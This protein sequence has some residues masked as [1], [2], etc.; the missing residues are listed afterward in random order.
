MNKILGLN[1]ALLLFVFSCKSKNQTTETDVVEQPEAANTIVYAKNRFDKLPIKIGKISSQFISEQIS[2]TGLVDVPPE[3]MASVSFVIGGSIKS[4]THNILPGKYVKKGSVLAV[5]QSI[6][7]L[8]IQDDYLQSFTKSELLIQEYTR[9]KS[10]AEEDAGAKRKLQEAENNL[11]LNKAMLV[12]LEA[13]L[14]LIGVN[15]EVLKKGKILPVFNIYSPING[16]IKTANVSTGKNFT[17]SDVLFEIVNNDHLHVEL[18]VFDKD[19]SKVREG[20]TV[21]FD[22][23]DGKKAIAKIFLVGKNFEADTK[24]LNI[25]VHFEDE[26]FEHQLI[27]GQS[28]NGKIL[29][30]K[31][32]ALILPESAIR[33][34]ENGNY[35]YE[36]KTSNAKEII[37]NKRK[38]KIGL[39]QNGFVEILENN[40]DLDIITEGV[41]LIFAEEND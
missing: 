5:G 41:N 38:I 13:K 32:Q 22:T 27:L 18:K 16:Y 8:Q 34:E 3:N 28:L 25:H 11:K 21:V 4:L 24:T 2:A 37:L 19:G 10:L 7:F 29:I 17:T 30:G 31:K 20:Q 40:I 26:T 14:R 9:Q 23:K 33:R 35:I 6:E 36:I 1:L 12:G 15:I 39:S